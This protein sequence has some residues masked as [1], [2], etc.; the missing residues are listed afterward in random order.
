[1]TAVIL[2]LAGFVSTI[3]GGLLAL[4]FRDR[5]HFLLS[6]TAH[7]LLGVVSFDV[8]P[9][10]FELAERLQLGV[11]R[12]MVALVAG[13]LFFHAAEKFVLLHHAHESGYADHRHPHVGVVSALAL[14]GHS[15]LDGVGIGL[16][17]QASTAVG[18]SVAIAVI[19]HDFSDG[20][21]TVGL[22]LAHRNTTR[23]SA[24]M[25]VLDALAP[26]LGAGSTLLFQ[27]PASWLIIY[28]GFFA[29]FLLYIGA[30]DI[31][32]EAHSKASPS[33]ALKLI[34]LTALG[35]AFVFAVARAAEH[36]P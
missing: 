30:A 22:M 29:G 25:L 23:R 28:L 3:G 5:L 12:A 14:I 2:S 16:A 33:T 6:F 26:V 1:M 13:F 4:K 15:I 35:A 32:P 18:I 24:T 7:V 10:I 31:L 36:A 21:N 11:M 9:E 34:G 27:A 20:L 17:F 8:L 19:A